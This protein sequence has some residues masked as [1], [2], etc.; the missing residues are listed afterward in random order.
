[1]RLLTA[2]EIR[3]LEECAVNA[4]VTMEQLMENAGTTCA[5]FIL[6]KMDVEGR[7]VVI[8]CGKGNNGGDGFV[9]ARVL[10]K[11]GA[12]V[13]VVLMQGAPA[14]ELAQQAY[15]KMHRGIEIILAK[16]AGAVLDSADVI[17]DAVFGFGF[18]GRIPHT[19]DPVIERANTAKALRIAVDLPSGAVC[20]TGA[21][22]GMCFK[23]DYTVTFT[24]MK[25]ACAVYPAAKYCG[26]T[27][28]RQ[29]GI[30]H[31]F[32][33]M[34]PCDME[35]VHLCS[36]YPLFQKRDPEGHKGTYGRLLMVCG[37]IGMAG[38]CI[39]AARAAL[40]SGVG[41][42]DIAVPHALY[43]ILATAIPEAV[44]TLYD[45]DETM[46]IRLE[47]ALR[48]ADA[49]LIGC[50]LGTAAYAARLVDA[51]LRIADCPLVLDADALNLTAATPE[52]LLYPTQPVVVTPHP[53]EMSRLT[54]KS[55]E[56]IRMDRIGT[57]KAFAA[58]YRTVTVLK[59]AG[60]VIA[61][62]KGEIGVNT[63]G[64]PGMAK[65]G[66]GDVLAGM[67][68]ALLAQKTDPY[69]AARAAVCLHGAAGD[70]CAERLSEHAMLPT[71][72][73][74]ALPSV[75]LKVEEKL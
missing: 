35:T 64:N 70:R 66:S 26:K 53:G 10:E 30:K 1:M 51:V 67:I 68:G 45:T 43:P 4:G 48:K 25:P 2:G 73:I 37:S 3:S 21:V 7:N 69:M 22:E 49:C 75:F 38:A 56:E 13:T 42:L 36:L 9:I 55:M 20:D 57:A 27:V 44:F 5:E 71:D 60:T 16:N 19:M 41:L 6:E 46:E 58:K 32:L 62:P 59:G 31:E 11:A 47:A 24:A 17:V 50:G 63:T 23:A 52:K 65:G 74:E 33:D 72:L 18:S 8:L 40:R 54:G 34:L 61:S 29:V 14:T 28:V 39:M 12:H 15:D